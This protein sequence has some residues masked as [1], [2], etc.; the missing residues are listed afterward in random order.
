MYDKWVAHQIE[1]TDPSIKRAFQLMNQIIANNSMIAG[2]RARALGQ[3]WDQG[4][5][6][7]VT[8]PKAEF[9]QEAT[10]VGAGLRGDLPQAKEGVDYSAFPFPFIKNWR[11]TPG[12]V[13]PNGVV[14]FNDTPGARA[15]ITCLTDPKALA[16]WARLGGYLSPNSG[17]AMSAYPNAL[18]R[19]VAQ[20]MTKAGNAG[21]LRMD[22]S[23]LM[24]P[25]LGSDYEF[26]ALQK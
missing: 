19:S 6:Q 25:K 10:F 8:D 15:L 9:F 13:G 3:R 12:V 18:T 20:L 16:Q 23:D 2:G 1:W 22:A 5:K 4:A 21:L 7:M 26:T 11:T 24:P 14:M 17:L